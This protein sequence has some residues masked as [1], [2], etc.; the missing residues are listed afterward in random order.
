MNEFKTSSAKEGFKNVSCTLV[1]KISISTTNNETIML[2]I[3]SL[4]MDEI[5]YKEH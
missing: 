2:T 3:F 5:K 1:R 4:M